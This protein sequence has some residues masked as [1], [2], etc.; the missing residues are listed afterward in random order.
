M[1][2]ILITVFCLLPAILMAQVTKSPTPKNDQMQVDDEM[3]SCLA[4][5][6]P[7]SS[8]EAQKSF[9]KYLKKEHKVKTK[10]K[11]NKLVGKNL[12][13]PTISEH[14]AH[15]EAHFTPTKEGGSEMKVMLKSKDGV[16]TDQEVDAASH[17]ELS[18]IMVN[19]GKQAQYLHHDNEID[20]LEDAY[21]NL[22]DK[23]KAN[24]ST[25]KAI[26]KQEKHRKELTDG[27]LEKT[28]Y[29]HDASGEAAKSHISQIEDENK[30]LK[31]EMKKLEDKIE[32]K[33]DHQKKLKRL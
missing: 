24:Q 17:Q 33:E 5:E 2:K 9:C 13:L 8:K 27:Q 28:D 7:I 23:Y 14:P 26:E 15:M 30:Q 16:H 29:N 32:E 11:D 25:I 19:Y 18:A 4:M 22:K 20:D 10:M 3:V 31:R 1:K 12:E 21:D 6:L